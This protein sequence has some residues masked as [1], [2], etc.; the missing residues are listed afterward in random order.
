MK[1]IFTIVALSLLVM[2]AAQDLTLQGRA[3]EVTVLL[4]KK[5]TATENEI[6]QQLARA[7]IVFTATLTE[8]IEGG[9]AKSLPP[10]RLYSL[11]LT[12]VKAIRGQVPE[13]VR[14]KYS[15]RSMHPPE[16]SAGPYTVGAH[17][18]GNDLYIDVLNPPPFLPNCKDETTRTRLEQL[19]REVQRNP[20]AQSR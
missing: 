20:E 17:F 1:R 8:A 4:A 18:N 6:E 10:V 16:F 15:V 2:P 9:I 7:E 19:I 5:K 12:G 3:D 11:E 14:G 13:K